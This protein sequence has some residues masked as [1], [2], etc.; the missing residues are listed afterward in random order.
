MRILMKIDSTKKDSKWEALSPM[1]YSHET[2]LQ[3]LLKTGSAELIPADPSLDEAH[4]VFA[5]EVS[6]DS[7]PIDLIGI[8]SSG[9]ITIME[10]KLARNHQIKREVVGQVLD[11]AA[12]LWETDILSL[13]ENFRARADADPFEALRQQFG[14]DPESFEE[15]RCRSEVARRLREGDFRLL[16]AVDRIDP[17]LRRIIQYVNSRGGT[18]QGLRLVAVE[19]PR[20]Q[21]GTIQVLVP[22]AYGDELARP[23]PPPKARWDH[24][25]ALEALERDP[26]LGE[27]GRD[28]TAWADQTPGVSYMTASRVAEIIPAIMVDGV[29]TPLLTLSIEG[30]VYLGFPRWNSGMLSEQAVRERFAADIAAAV[31][32]PKPIKARGWSHFDA[33]LLA[34]ADARL[35]FFGVLS[36][37]VAKVASAEGELTQSDG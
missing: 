9:S 20:Y 34:D 7:G 19:F 37:L 8:G 3:G 14:E 15:E 6:T 31:R 30:R 22:E 10:C 35:R 26:L 4:V 24:V 2:E 11:Y 18:G 16:V 28:L 27:L 12:S 29:Q 1:E 21:Q 17:E 23:A 25:Q 33:A 32:P 13:S 36:D 5:R